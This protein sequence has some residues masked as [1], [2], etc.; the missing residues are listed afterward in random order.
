M[1]G[2]GEINVVS[3]WLGGHARTFLSNT[4]H[5]SPFP[6][7]PRSKG[8][9]FMEISKAEY[10]RFVQDRAKKSPLVKDCA[11]AFG[12]G[13]VICVIGQLIMGIGRAHV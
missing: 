4:P 8:G 13:G 5:S 1:G 7:H 2:I 9:M 12:I 6:G 3:Q 10:Q 11:M